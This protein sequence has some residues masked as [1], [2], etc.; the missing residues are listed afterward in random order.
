VVG[1]VAVKRLDVVEES[2]P[3]L[4][5]AAS[6]VAERHGMIEKLKPETRTVRGGRDSNPRLLDRELLLLPT[7]VHKD[8]LALLGANFNRSV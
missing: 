1:V 6:E 8:T 5:E 7:A 4:E 3:V 2:P